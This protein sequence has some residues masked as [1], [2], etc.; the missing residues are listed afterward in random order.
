[1]RGEELRRKEKKKD[2]LQDQRNLLQDNLY[3]DCVFWQRLCVYLMYSISFSVLS[4]SLFQSSLELFP[5]WS[6]S[7]IHSRRKSPKLHSFERRIHLEKHMKKEG[8]RLENQNG[9]EGL[10]KHHVQTTILFTNKLWHRKVGKESLTSKGFAGKIAFR[11]TV[12]RERVKNTVEK[13][14]EKTEFL[15]NLEIQFKD[16][17]EHKNEECIQERELHPTRY[18][19]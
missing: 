13:K 8:R 15:R 7:I 17:N 4:P 10:S 6:I 5:S 19:K 16:R 18:M 1:M 12:E 14:K 9:K 2:L 11:L 3:R